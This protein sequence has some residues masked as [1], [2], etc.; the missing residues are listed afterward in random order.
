M[1]KIFYVF[2]FFFFSS[3]WCATAQNQ[4]TNLPTIYINTTNNA[5]VDSK[6]VYVTGTIQV[7][8]SNPSEN[9]TE[10]LEIRGRGNSTWGF[11][12]KPYRIK[13]NSKRNFLSLPAK[14]KSWV[15]LANYCDKT[16]MRNAVA[17]EIGKIVGLEYTPSVKFADVYLNG[18]YLGNY[19]ITDQIEVGTNRVP[20]EEQAITDVT[21]PAITGGYLIE[22]DGFA[23]SEPV[24]FS[25]TKGVKVTVKYPKDDEI[26]AQQFA[27][28][29]TYIQNFESKLFSTDFKNSSTGY[30]AYVDSASLVNWYIACELTGNSDSF[31][32]T[33]IYKKRDNPKLFFGPMWD[34]DIAFNND[35][36]LGDATLKLMREY[37]HNPKAWI[38]RLWEDAWFQNAVRVRWKKLVD[39]G[40]ETKLLTFISQAA[41]EL[42]QSQQRNFVK[43]NILNTVVYREVYVFPT[44]AQ[45]IDYL[46]TYI[47]QRIAF[48]NKGFVSD[49]SVPVYPPFSPDAGS[50]YQIVNKTSGNAVDI[51]GQSF[52]ENMPLIFNTLSESKG[53]QLWRFITDVNG[54]FQIVNKAA[55]KAI[56][57]KGTLGDTL[58]LGTLTSEAAFKW[59]ILPTN[60]ENYYGIISLSSGYGFN[61]KGGS[62]NNGTPLIEWNSDIYTSSNAKFAF[63]KITTGLFNLIQ[64][65]KLLRT[66]YDKTQQTLRIVFDST[67]DEASDLSI[68]S[69]NGCVVKT[70][71][72]FMLTNIVNVSEL[73]QGVYIVNLRTDQSTA[74]AKFIKQ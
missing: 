26:N 6:E 35:Y 40:I 9:F 34:Y 62:L 33:Y 21:E 12:K 72:S 46:K 58:V 25:T 7:V 56:K 66:Y 63:K 60:I 15:L 71:K 29:K 37:A 43:W 52:V 41:T 23:D 18:T 28:I 64:D 59:Q 61:N 32:S 27:Y 3:Q 39:D 51:N 42:E 50:Y 49:G 22:L 2:L 30:R 17:F 24:W 65:V 55:E 57:C 45:G 69:I 20:V 5:P 4:L 16:L 68:Y 36:R 19:T 70:I 48:L 53:T 14:A 13:L 38:Q 11:A 73:P 31:W 8:S 74:V 67:I 10:A 47:Q 54:N 44:Y 1:K